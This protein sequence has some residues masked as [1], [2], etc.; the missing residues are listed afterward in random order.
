[1][2]NY[3]ELAATA[4]AVADGDF[5]TAEGLAKEIAEGYTTL[6]ESKFR[7]LN[8]SDVIIHRADV[9][10]KLSSEDGLSQFA[11]EFSSEEEKVCCIT[12]MVMHHIEL[13][14]LQ[15]DFCLY[16]TEKGD[17]CIMLKEDSQIKKLDVE[18]VR[19][20]LSHIEVEYLGI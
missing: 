9:Q 4:K 20:A 8:I 7:K 17:L 15:A 11:K 12:N 2:K 16:R 1:M 19:D 5:A 6:L 14:F 3:Q 10:R 13:L 18:E